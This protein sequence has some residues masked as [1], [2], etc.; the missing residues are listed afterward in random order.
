MKHEEALGE[1]LNKF[2]RLADGEGYLSHSGLHGLRGV[3]E[4]LMFS[5]IGA[6]VEIPNRVYKV[7]SSLGPKLYFY[8]AKFRE[9]TKQELK[10]N[11]K[12]VPFRIKTRNIKDALFAYLKCLEACPLMVNLVGV[13]NVDGG[14]SSDQSKKNEVAIRRT[15]EWDGSKDA[16]DAID[17]MADL[18]LLLARIRG[19]AY[20]FESKSSKAK[21]TTTTSEQ[22]QEEE[23]LEEAFD[24]NYEYS[25]EQPVIEHAS[26]VNTILYNIACAH[27]FELHGRNYITMEDIPIVIKVA[28]SSANRNRVSCDHIFPSY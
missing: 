10:S 19:N 5:L 23:A 12:G 21:L 2:T 13:P 28:L 11:L 7:L 22:D 3:D 24:Y 9:P 18:A 6:T 15:I 17:M 1:I 4:P 14:L 27:A 20:A 8:R 26:R 16:E 25:F